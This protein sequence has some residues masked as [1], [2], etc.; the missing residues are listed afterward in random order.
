MTTPSPT[1]GHKMPAKP[2]VKHDN[3]QADLTLK[4]LASARRWVA[5]SGA[6]MPDGKINKAP[7]NP[8]TGRA[9]KNNTPAT[10]GTRQAAVAR[11]KTLKGHGHKPGVGIEM[12]DLGDG[13]FLCGVDLDGCHDKGL[14]PWAEEVCNRIDSYA[15]VSPSDKGVKAFFRVRAEDVPAIRKAMGKDFRAEWKSDKHYGLELHVCHSYFTVTGRAYG[16]RTDALRLVPLADVLWII[17]TAAPAF[18]KGHGERDETRSADAFRLL[19][20]LFRAGSTEEQAVAD[21]AADDG[22]AGDWWATTDERQ[23]ERAVTRAKAQA[24]GEEPTADF[25]DDMVAGLDDESIALIWGPK[26]K[27]PRFDLDQD[28][29]IRA[30]TDRHK[31]KLL[32]D[33]HRGRWHLFNSVYWQREETK[34]ALHYALEVSTELAKRDARAKPLKNM[35]TWEA[36]ERGARTDRAFACTSEKWDQDPMLLGTPGGTVDLRTGQLRKARP[37][38]YISKITAVAPDPACNIPQWLAFLD[39]AMGGDAGAIRFLQQWAGYC[40]TGDT[41]EQ[42]LLFV[43]GEGGSGKGTAINTIAA[44]LKDYAVAMATSTLTAKKYEA[45]PEEIARLHGPRMAV[46]SETEKGSKWAENRIKGLTGQD[47]LTAR[48]MRENSFDFRPQFKLTIFGNNAPSLS[49]VDSAIRRRFLILPFSRKPARKDVTLADKLKAEWPGI[50]SW[51]IQGCLD[52][53]ANGLVR[54]DVVNAATESYFAEQDTFGKWIADCCEVGV[55]KAETTEVL[56]QSWQRYA[57]GVSE[58]AGSKL[59]AFPERM[60]QR[61]FKPGEKIGATRGRGF[62]GVRLAEEQEGFTDDLI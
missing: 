8:A 54:P 57:Y 38:D 30:F 21:I 9:A 29:I 46:A 43:Y 59:R 7:L 33:H 56:Y 47:T 42:V 39:F 40:L 48:Y 1:K 35:P 15:E 50:L 22:T 12:G 55:G 41:R 37:D 51:M 32:F 5:Y 31:G 58:E 16:G 25:T 17:N 23:K 10:W 44:I 24:E 36:V 60:E 20:D 18:L 13:T 49:D 26:A 45:H 62:K 6:P 11:T 2:T 19:L 34:L 53:Q 52:W 14:E 61:G 27:K 3:R 28:G 4:G